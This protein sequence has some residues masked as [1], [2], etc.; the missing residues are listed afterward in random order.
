MEKK[1]RKGIALTAFTERGRELA[2]GLAAALGGTLREKDR[3]LPDWTRESFQSCEALVFIGA[4]GIAVR[5]VA[6]HLQSKAAD[7]AV[8]WGAGSSRSSPAISAGPTPSPSASPP[9]PGARP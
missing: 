8:I 1:R 3:P 5:S 4:A 2:S 9:S 7:P 6:P